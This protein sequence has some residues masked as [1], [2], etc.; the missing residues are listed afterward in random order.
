MKELHPS[1]MSPIFKA[2]KRSARG[3]PMR[4]ALRSTV[5]RNSASSVGLIAARLT[6]HQPATEAR[7]VGH[8][9]FIPSTT[10]FHP[11]P[12]LL[13]LQTSP[14]STPDLASFHFRPRLLQS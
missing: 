9:P 13:P 10:F 6:I 11:R 1:D 2:V 3:D 12:H 5:V 14:P 4:A 8:A 7:A